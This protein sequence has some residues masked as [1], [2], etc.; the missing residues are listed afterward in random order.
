LAEQGKEKHKKR[1]K[2]YQKE[3]DDF[4]KFLLDKYLNE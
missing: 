4:A 1:L 2:K 3:M